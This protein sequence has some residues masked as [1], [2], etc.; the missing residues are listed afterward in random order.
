MDHDVEDDVDVGAALG[1]RREALALD[2]ARLRDEPL[3][4]ADRRVEPLEVADLEH[5]L[6]AD[7]ELEQLL[8]IRDRRRERLLDEDVD[9]RFRSSRATAGGTAC[10]RRR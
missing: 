5:A 2:E 9:P 1:E 8:A 3:D 4:R 7:R 10:S 6:G